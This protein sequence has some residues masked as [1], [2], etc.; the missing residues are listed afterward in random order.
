MVCTAISTPAAEIFLSIVLGWQR[1][2]GRERAFE[3][4]DRP[5]IIPPILIT[6]KMKTEG[7]TLPQKL[8]PAVGERII[9]A[10]IMKRTA[11]EGVFLLGEIAEPV[12]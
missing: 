6:P 11:T 3:V 1:F 10:E 2:K 9:G 5:G 8:F 4:L 7:S 12:R